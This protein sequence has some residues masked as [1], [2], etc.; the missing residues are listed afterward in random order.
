M[1][2]QKASGIRVSLGA[3]ENGI[4]IRSYQ[5]IIQ[6]PL[7]NTIT[8]NYATKEEARNSLLFFIG[9][10]SNQEYLIVEM[11]DRRIRFVW[12]LGGGA[13]Q[14]EHPM[15]IETNDQGLVKDQQW[16]K[17]E[18]IRIGNQASLSVKRTPD[19]NKQ[20]NQQVSAISAPGYN[21]LD[22][23]P[24]GQFYIGGLPSTGK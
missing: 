24:N 19:G 18:V 2:R 10:N 16:Y 8:I 12:N 14:L 23:D 1:S 11:V 17:I 5:S 15:E 9:S 20:D 21:R 4:C 7:T 3:N 13:A 22:I 6:S